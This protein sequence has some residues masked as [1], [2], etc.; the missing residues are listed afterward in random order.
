MELLRSGVFAGIEESSGDWEVLGQLIA[1]P[2]QR[3]S[4]AAEKLHVLCN[5]ERGAA[6]GGVRNR[7]RRF[8]N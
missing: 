1:L 4:A 7:Q 6:G 2:V 5:G 3:A 8:R